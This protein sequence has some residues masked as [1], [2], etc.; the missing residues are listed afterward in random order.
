ML[1]V[2]PAAP[3]A[4]PANDH[5]VRFYEHDGQLVDEVTDFLDD[6]LRGDGLAIAIATPAH[7]TELLRGLSGFGGLLQR[8]TTWFSGKLVMLDAAETLEQLM[9]LGRPDP[10]RMEALLAP[11]LGRVSPGT[12][13]HAFGEMVALLCERGEYEAAL[14]L[15]SLWNDLASRHRFSLFCAY[16]RRLFS[17]A[18]HA[19]VYRHVCAAHSEV[20]IDPDTEGLPQLAEEP[21]QT[22]AR[23]REQVRA[24]QAEVTRRRRAE[25]TLRQR[26]RDLA[27]FL[28]NA[29]EGIHKVAADGTILYAN[30]AELDMLGYSWEEYVGH[31][32]A[33]F[34][35][36]QDLIR[37]IIQR[38]QRGEE[39]HDQPALL[40][41]KDG[42]ARP[43]RIYSNACFE[44][45][46]LRYTRC[47][48]R[49][50][51]ARV[52]LDQALAERER[53]LQDLREASRAKD[54]FL[55]MLGHELRNPLSPIVT[56]LQ[57][58]RMRGDAGTTRE[59]A[60]I[61]RQVD[62]MVRLV[63]DLLDTSR[64]TRG[65]IELKREQVEVAAVLAK[66][67]EQAGLLLEQR[68]HRLDVDVAPG[69]RCEGDPVR[70]AQVV[71]NLLT[72]SA[73][74]TDIGGAIRLEA[75]VEADAW[76]AIRVRDNGAGIAPEM[77]PKVF[78]LF[79][80]GE[81]GVDRRQ[82]GL[83]IG[84]ALVRS[85]VELHGGSVEAHSEGRGCGSEFVV[86]L[87][88]RAD[89]PAAESQPAEETARESDSRGCKVL[90]VDDN[91]DAAE[92]LAQLLGA[93]G[94][95]VTV[96][97]DP[98]SA[99]EHLLEVR[100]EVAVLDIGLPVMDGYELGGRIRKVL[101]DSCLLVALT[102]YGQD[103]DRARSNAAGFDRHL[104][105]PVPPEEVLDLLTARIA[106]E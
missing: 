40:R 5:S 14:A 47:F 50:A 106:R 99:L 90:V 104:V 84:L 41:C 24:L 86:R 54:E 101:G 51:S 31:N 39:L 35:V 43:V 105:K 96:F 83:G 45:G 27:E 76:V 34:Y 26:E 95:E 71:A 32:V 66:A 12:P 33:E 1:V 55:A 13:V 61:Q 8:S 37:Q 2:S 87:P 98:A 23:L 63:D 82:G 56:A 62:H 92:T 85:L 57:L 75:K 64:I 73:R 38:L 28:D 103:A 29:S 100:P 18:E 21:V 15:E 9:L 65:K 20:L 59:Q 36:D 46:E 17:A 58:M 88:W 74:Y 69:L 7:R 16:P 52:A 4:M 11:V 19:Q 94:H 67:V 79:Y 77:L 70:L 60:I 97:H 42:S 3:A 25:Q 80:Q 89:A 10:A 44:K 49:D 93:Y 48:T 6:A 30:R 53:L 81:Q 91:V 102:G 78:E 72:N 22:A 68:S